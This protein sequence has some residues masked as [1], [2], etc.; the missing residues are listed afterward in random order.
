M[1]SKLTEQL[2]KDAVSLAL[3]GYSD[4]AICN[5]LQL[6]YSTL[7]TKP[8]LALLEAIK[9][10]R[11]EA[12]EQILQDLLERSKS[13]TGA[14][15]SI[16]LAKK[17]KVFE[18]VYATAKPKDISE[19]LSRIADIYESVADGTLEAD[20]GDKL[21]NY[22]SNYIKAFEISELE[23]RLTALENK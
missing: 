18:P 3:R 23:E 15:A 4:K 17:L 14:T 13:D 19:A 5:T 22:L 12:K 21:V 10:A 11:N 20:K 1:K 6:G 8:Y 9:R 2:Q 7:Y 16:F